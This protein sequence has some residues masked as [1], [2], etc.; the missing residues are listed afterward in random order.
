MLVSKIPPAFIAISLCLSAVSTVVGAATGKA[1]SEANSDDQSGTVQPSVNNNN[2]WLRKP[3]SKG[4]KFAKKCMKATEGFLDNP[5]EYGEI[6]QGIHPCPDMK[7]PSGSGCADKQRRAQASKGTTDEDHVPSMSLYYGKDRLQ[8][9][10]EAQNWISV[11][12]CGIMNNADLHLLTADVAEKYLGWDQKVLYQPG[13]PYASDMFDVPFYRM[14]QAI[15]LLYDNCSYTHCVV[16][17]VTYAKGS[18]KSM[19]T[20]DPKDPKNPENP[21][22]AN[23]LSARHMDDDEKFRVFLNRLGPQ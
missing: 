9:H 17:G 5:T 12:R 8:K 1:L 11:A 7:F 13:D 14:T 2:N 18:K 15:A 16:S 19:G 3:S 4:F 21:Q 23:D 10:P 6:L 20:K 22:F